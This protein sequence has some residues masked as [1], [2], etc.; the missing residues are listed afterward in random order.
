MEIEYKKTRGRP[1]TATAERPAAT[2]QA[3]DRALHLLINLAETDRA[4]LTEVTMQTGTAP[5]TAHRLLM[6]M[7]RR[8]IVAFDEATQNWMIGVEAFRI[9]SSFLRRTRVVEAGRAVMRELMEA[10]G[11][12]ANIA[13]ADNADVTLFIINRPTPFS[14][15]F[16][17]GKQGWSIDD[18]VS[19]KLR[20]DANGLI[21]PT[22][23]RFFTPAGRRYASLMVRET[24]A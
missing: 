16:K 21:W 5:S 12:T 6:T 20:N 24:K 10:T 4:T 13:I 1:R 22:G 3:L 2:V 19:G 17:I 18:G 14:G 23:G 7:Q 11:E 8:G 15:A 9:G